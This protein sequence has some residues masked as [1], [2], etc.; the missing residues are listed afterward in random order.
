MPGRPKTAVVPT[1]PIP[2]AAAWI[3]WVAR[4]VPAPQDSQEG[5]QGAPHL[6]CGGE[7]PGR[8]GPG[9]PAP[10][11]VSRRDQRLAGTGLAQVGR[12]VRRGRRP[13]THAVAVSG[14]PLRGAVAGRLD[15]P[16]EAVGDAVVPAA[17]MG[18]VLAGAAVVAGGG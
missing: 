1:Y 18:R 16:A 10:R 15:H 8:G 7:P 6:Q 3:V 4:H 14:G 17:A 5:R 12:S 11:A 13:A 2:G 9:G